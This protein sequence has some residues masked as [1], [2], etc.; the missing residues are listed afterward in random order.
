MAAGAPNK[1]T[2]LELF[3]SPLINSFLD[4]VTIS[5]AGDFLCFAKMEEGI[6]GRPFCE[7]FFI[8]KQMQEKGPKIESR[9]LSREGVCNNTVSPLP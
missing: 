5:S 6:F 7:R 4:K 2:A 9:L 8:T 1:A 3:A